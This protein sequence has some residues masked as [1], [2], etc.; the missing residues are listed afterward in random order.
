MT[1]AGHRLGVGLGHCAM[2]R[3]DKRELR[4]LWR[5]ELSQPRRALMV[6]IPAQGFSSAR[7]PWTL[8]PV[9]GV[10]RRRSLDRRPHDLG[11]PA[12]IGGGQHDPG[13]PNVL[14]RAVPIRHDRLEAIA[15]RRA[16]IE[17]GTGAHPRDSYQSSPR[18]SQ[19]G[20]N[21]QILSTSVDGFPHAMHALPPRRPCRHAGRGS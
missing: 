5:G 15:I 8:K 7:I 1:V 13:S 10:E 12:T 9:P 16:C 4:R 17:G 18:G 3:S 11:R 6:K 14:L 20:I 2:V 21:R 19:I